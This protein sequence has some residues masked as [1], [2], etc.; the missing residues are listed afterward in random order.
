MKK[1]I[2]IKSI[3][4]IIL[5]ISI[6]ILK[7]KNYQ[8]LGYKILYVQSGS[9]SPTFQKGD[10]VI[11]K[12]C[13]SYEIGEIITYSVEE[14]LITHRIIEKTE[15]GYITKGDANNTPDE[16]NVDSTQIKGKV[17]KTVI[18]HHLIN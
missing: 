11:I 12:K 16:K 3:C 18:L 13:K 14:N 15:N 7:S 8:P 5:A 10:I 1:E 6:I 4:V 9:M 17:I 2:L